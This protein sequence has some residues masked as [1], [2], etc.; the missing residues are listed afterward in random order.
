MNC[1]LGRISVD[2]FT[3]IIKYNLILTLTCGIIVT[4]M[5]YSINN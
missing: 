1:M 5:E 4:I 2:L 3:I